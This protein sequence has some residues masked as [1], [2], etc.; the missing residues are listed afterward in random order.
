M[1]SP[2]EWVCSREA[3]VQCYTNVGEEHL[4]KDWEAND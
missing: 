1:K 2:K 4:A 3:E